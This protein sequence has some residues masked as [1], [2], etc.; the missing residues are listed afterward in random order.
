M[1]PICK[2]EKASDVLASR[3]DWFGVPGTESVFAAENRS[4]AASLQS[5]DRSGDCRASDQPLCSRSDFSSYVL[6]LASFRMRSGAASFLETGERAWGI[7]QY[8]NWMR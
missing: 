5:V 1:F 2:V 7:R 8:G 4:G 3:A 6:S